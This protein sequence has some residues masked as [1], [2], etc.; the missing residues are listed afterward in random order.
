MQQLKDNIPIADYIGSQI[1]LKSNGSNMVGLCPFHKEKTPSFTVSNSKGIYKCF[2][3]GKSGSVIDFAMEYKSLNYIDACKLLSEKYHIPIEVNV[4]VYDRPVDRL[5]KLS[6][7]A[8]KYFEGRGISN[9]TLLR[10]NVTETIEWMPKA[11]KEVQAICFNYY[12]DDQLVNIKFRAKD[13][14][15]KLNK[16][17]ELIFYN[18]DSLKDETTAVIV[19]GEIDCL[20]CYEAGI[21]NVVSVPNGAGNNLQYLDSCWQ[22]FEGI[23]KIILAVDNDDPGYTLRD[24]LARRLGKERCF[25]VSYPDGCKDLNDVLIKHTKYGVIS[26]IEQAVNWPIDGVHPMDDLYED[27]CNYYENGYPKGCESKIPGL[28]DLITFAPGQLTIVTGIPGH[29]KSE[30]VD[31]IMS[32]LTNYHQW[33]WGV[34]SFENPPAF[35]VTKLMEK[36]SGKSFQFRVN[37]DH[38][39]NKDEFEDSVGIIDRHFSFININKIDVTIDGVLAKAKELVLRKGIKG[40][41]IDPWN[42]IELNIPSTQTETQYISECLTKLRM[43]SVQT[44]THVFLVAHPTKMRKDNG[45]YEV[46]NLYSISGS[47]HFFNKTDNGICIFR[48]GVVTCYVQKIRFSWQGSL[49]YAQFNY[50]TFTRQYK[51]V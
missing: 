20:S 17:S 9:N 43:F 24:E 14:D 47:A 23:T 29:G 39:I 1:T 50:D 48:D 31:Y 7:V 26:T 3:C 44:G 33:S 36:F 51:A 35:H 5:T 22:V 38:R 8:L 2:G 18:I 40:L 12:K 30:F 49:G 15:F 21:Y 10:F 13:K 19:E 16:N 28:D 37:H 25:K 45:K 11:N 32:Q 46:P 42:Y 6:E 34:C 27:V 41:L 4:K